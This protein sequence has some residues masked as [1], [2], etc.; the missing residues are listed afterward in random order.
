MNSPKKGVMRFALFATGKM[1]LFRL[2]NQTT[3]A[4]LM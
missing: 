3:E 4:G 2:K 1:I